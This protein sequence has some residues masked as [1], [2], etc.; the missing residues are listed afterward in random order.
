MDVIGERQGVDV[1]R[2]AN[3]IKAHVCDLIQELDTNFQYLGVKRPIDW[4]RRKISYYNK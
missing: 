2:R 1:V 3:K 4:G